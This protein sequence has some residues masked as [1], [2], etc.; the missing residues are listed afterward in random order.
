MATSVAHIQDVYH[1]QREF[2]RSGATRPY[3]FRKAQIKKLHSAIKEYEPQILEALKQ[4]LGKPEFEAYGSEVGYMYNE[5]RHTLRYLKDW[6]AVEREPTSIAHFPTRSKVYSV[7]KGQVLI[8]APWNYPFMLILD[9]LLGA[10]AAGNTAVLKLPSQT[11]HTSEIVDQMISKHFDERYIDTIRIDD[12]DIIPNLITGNFRFDHI[13]FTGSTRVGHLIMAAAAEK[14]IPV[15]LELGGKSPAIVDSTADLKVTAKRIIWGKAFNAGQTCIAPDHVFVHH[16]VKTPLLRR[17]EL[18]AD[19]VMEKYGGLDGFS[20]IINLK[21]FE[22]LLSYLDGQEEISGGL[23]DADDL[24]LGLCIVDEP[25]MDS[26]LMQEEIFGP[27]LPVIAYTDE[28]D[29]QEKLGQ[30]PFPLAFYLFSKDRKKQEELMQSVPFGGGCINNCLIQISNPYVPF[31]GIGTSG[32][33]HYHGKKGFD[34][35]SH[36]K[37]ILK[38]GT[39]IDVPIRYVPY[40]AWKMKVLRL[41][42]R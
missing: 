17:L 19:E 10:M 15:T 14:L 21:R 22:T 37:S 31:G 20:R 13:F 38:T 7:P 33:G 36:K 24:K 12:T 30:N 3:R 27:I 8:L 39:W 32:L 23:V 34:T 2:F 4:D 18:E 42:F 9:P 6:M 1:A 16:E 11:P 26:A 40:R 29:L 5:I 28:A 25:G 41:L 35:F